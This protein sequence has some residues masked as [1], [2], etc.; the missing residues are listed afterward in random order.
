[1]P[2]CI[3]RCRNLGNFLLLLGIQFFRFISLRNAN[4]M[5]VTAEN[6]WLAPHSTAQQTTTLLSSGL[7][8][9]DF[10]VDDCCDASCSFNR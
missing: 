9:F 3:S 6:S 5:E 7:T 8:A 4:A 2:K 10:A 1:M